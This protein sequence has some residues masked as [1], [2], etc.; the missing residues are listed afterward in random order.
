MF[1]KYKFHKMDESFNKADTEKY[2][3]VALGCIKR[4][5]KLRTLMI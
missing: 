2:A 3:A 5:S 1:D 4:D